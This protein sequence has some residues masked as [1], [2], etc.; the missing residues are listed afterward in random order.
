MGKLTGASVTVGLTIALWGISINLLYV[1]GILACRPARWVLPLS[2]YDCVC[3]TLL[4]AGVMSFSVIMFPCH[5]D[6][7]PRIS[8]LPSLSALPP[9]CVCLSTILSLISLGSLIR[10][11]VYYHPDLFFVFSVSFSLSIS[12][13]ILMHSDTMT[14]CPYSYTHTFTN[15]LS[16]VST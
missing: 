10:R 16:Y 9:L 4:S 2:V 5:H 1:T 14:L 6:I 15:N 7:R 13:S 3:V 8:H 11:L 12:S